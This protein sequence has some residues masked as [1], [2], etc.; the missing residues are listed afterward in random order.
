[1]SIVVSLL[2]ASFYLLVIVL[3]FFKFLIDPFHGMLIP[4]ILLDGRDKVSKCQFL[5]QRTA[6]AFAGMMEK[7][8]PPPFQKVKLNV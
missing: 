3:I 7:P 5:M 4:T 8:P 6:I 2:L 1:M